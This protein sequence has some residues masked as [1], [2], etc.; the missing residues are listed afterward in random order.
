MESHGSFGHAPQHGLKRFLGAV[1]HIFGVV[2]GMD[3][4]EFVAGDERATGHDAAAVK[5]VADAQLLS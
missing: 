5:N 3:S 1:P 2:M 4:A